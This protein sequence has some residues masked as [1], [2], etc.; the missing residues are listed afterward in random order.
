MNGFWIV[1]YNLFLVPLLYGGLRL[2]GLWI[3]K[4]KKGIQ[5]RRTLFE[6]L[7][8]QL[9]RLQANRPRI[10]FHVASY[11]EF[12]QTK[13]VL[14]A[15]RQKFTDA[16]LILSF[17]SPSGYEHARNYP[18]VDVI[19]YLPFDS[20]SQA[21]KF[22]TLVQPT[23]AVIVRHDIWPNHLWQLNRHRIPIFLISA[24]LP[25]TTMR[26]LPVIRSF[27]KHLYRYFTQVL[28]ISE[29][30]TRRLK[31]LYPFEQ[32]LRVIGDTRYDQVYQ[33]SLETEK[34]KFLSSAT[35]L[36]NKTI[37][38]AGSTW[39]SDEKHLFPAFQ[40]LSQQRQNLVMILVPH[41]PS[42]ERISQIKE[43]LSQMQLTYISLSDY[44]QWPSGKNV[45]VLIVD[46][47]GLLA[48]L[49]SLGQFA[50][51]GGSFGPGVHNV[52]EPAVY[53]IP[54]F[55][56]PRMRNSF[57]AEKLISVG[58]G[59]V[60]RDAKEIYEKLNQF[61][62]DTEETKKIGRLARD[63]VMKNL[64]A[65]EKVVELIGTYLTCQ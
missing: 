56:G 15:L 17:F 50:Y 20:F 53:G 3:D 40:K 33:R 2:G 37:F 51:V 16:Y 47:M 13:P 42:P 61:L 64:G 8:L 30:S 23:V 22:V 28:A 57:E 4:I 19:T 58:A 25:E 38:V 21:R 24:S 12:E 48:N 65:S 55:F 46:K 6:T 60:V 34:L 43:Q 35:V 41:E 14:N 36:Q 45:D 7:Q 63:M 49:Y 44:Q 29:E 26:L 62:T 5:G 27:N 52:L 11:G 59:F 54:V 39:P 1:F 31:K 9:S 32:R 10:W 18:A